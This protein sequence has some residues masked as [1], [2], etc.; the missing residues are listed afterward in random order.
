[1]LGRCIG[2]LSLQGVVCAVPG[3]GRMLEG[4]S[5]GPP[6]SGKPVSRPPRGRVRSRRRLGCSVPA[7][8]AGTGS[9]PGPRRADF[10]GPRSL[11][12]ASTATVSEAPEKAA[13]G[14]VSQA[15]ARRPRRGGGGRHGAHLTPTPWGLLACRRARTPVAG[16][17]SAPSEPYL[18]LLLLCSVTFPVVVDRLRTVQGGHALGDAREKECLRRRGGL[19]PGLREV[20]RALTAGE[21]GPVGKRNKIAFSLLM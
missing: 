6:C 3:P 15:I 5:T 16:G 8:V 2:R 4:Q 17:T 11:S 12:P 7:S 1:M 18:L 20:L 14:P 10:Q 21:P 9:T 13:R 19:N